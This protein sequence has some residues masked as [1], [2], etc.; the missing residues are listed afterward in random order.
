MVILIFFPDDTIIKKIHE[1]FCS[2]VFKCVSFIIFNK[3]KDPFKFLRSFQYALEM[4]T[5]KYFLI[6]ICIFGIFMELQKTQEIPNDRN[7]FVEPFPNPAVD[8]DEKKDADMGL[9]AG[10]RCDPEDG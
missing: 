5:A 4:E 2:L 8:F 3:I 10:E 7:N 9:L 1:F 6:Y